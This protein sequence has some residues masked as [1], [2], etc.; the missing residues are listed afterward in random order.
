MRRPAPV[1]HAPT[2]LTA[3]LLRRWPLPPLDGAGSKEDRGQVLVVGG[4][5]ELPG[6][7]L[8]AAEAALR[9]G[10]GKLQASTVRSVA[11]TLAVGLPEAKVMALPGRAGAITGATV[12]L[13]K[14][15]ATADAVL[16]G[17]GMEDA[18]ATRR[19]V[20]AL[21]GAARCPV[22]LDAGAL[23]AVEGLGPKRPPL[24]LTPHLGEMASLRREA[25]ERIAKRQAEVT[26][27]YA[28]THGVALALK[29][30]TTVVSDEEGTAWVYRH[31]PVGLGTSGSGDVLAGVAAGLVARGA[32]P[33]QA[34]AW[35]VFVH[36]EA[37]R[38][39]SRRVG[40]VG[41][42]ARE[43]LAEVPRVLESLGTRT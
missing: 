40:R 18:P 12:A 2:P 31:G 11:P 23:P 15:A 1:D 9:A 6:S 32:T 42:L 35:A 41:F 25:R 5:D 13:R 28:R 27:E 4:S 7:L 24:L 36:G 17:C 14:A 3:A 33:A 38:R 30:A 19:L 26:V 43:L 16:V 39:L 20:R 21:S 29:G 8:L 22:V 37:G 34:L 10:A